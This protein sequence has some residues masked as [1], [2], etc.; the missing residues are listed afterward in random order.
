MLSLTRVI[1]SRTSII[2]PRAVTASGANRCFS[3]GDDLSKKVRMAFIGEGLAVDVWYVM[4][5]EPF[6]GGERCSLFLIG[7]GPF[8]CIGSSMEAH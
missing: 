5:S 7:F 4:I 6:V 1:A 3:I 2:A 8:G